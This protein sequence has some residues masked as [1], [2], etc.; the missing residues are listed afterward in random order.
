MVLKVHS[1]HVEFVLTYINIHSVDW[2]ITITEHLK[3]ISIFSG[4][5][6]V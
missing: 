2:G 4:F 6:V 1:R 3:L 5:S